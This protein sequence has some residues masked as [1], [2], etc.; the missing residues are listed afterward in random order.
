MLRARDGECLL[1]VGNEGNHPRVAFIFWKHGLSFFAPCPCLRGSPPM[2][3][4]LSKSVILYWSFVENHTCPER[5][6]QRS[7]DVWAGVLCDSVQGFRKKPKAA[8]G[9]F[10]QRAWNG[11]GIQG[12]KDGPSAL[13]KT[14][15]G[16]L[17]C[18]GL[19][20]WK[21]Q[22]CGWLAY[23]IS[24]K[25]RTKMVVSF[26]FPF[27]ATNRR[28][29]TPNKG[30]IHFLPLHLEAPYWNLS[31]DFQLFPTAYF[32]SC[33]THGPT[34]VGKRKHWEPTLHQLA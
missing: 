17:L 27:K 23:P 13:G 25:G 26:W 7:L 30:H 18:Q 9:G 8:G 34:S 11:T 1:S 6:V 19:D 14:L 21:R 4:G 22:S 29:P 2:N 3:S 10:L 31:C 28:V 33:F 12:A 15:A 16:A 20:S 5:V 24:C 32:P